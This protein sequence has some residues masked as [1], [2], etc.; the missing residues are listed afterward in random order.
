MVYLKKESKS[1]LT[2]T[3]FLMSLLAA[4]TSVYASHSASTATTSHSFYTFKS[5]SDFSWVGP[6]IGL[7][8]GG[9]SSNAQMSSTVG[10]VTDTSYF[11][12]TADVNSVAQAGSIT[13][14]PSA[15]I[16]GVQF[17]DNLYASHG[18]L[19]GMVLDY[20][21]LHLSQSST[22]NVAYPSGIG[23]Y[24]M[25]TSMDTDWLYTIRGR[26][27]YIPHTSW[28]MMLYGTGGL[29]VTNLRATNSFNDT[30]S[31]AGQGGSSNSNNQTGWTLGLG[32]EFP[33]VQHL[34]INAEYLYLHFGRVTSTGSIQNTSAG[35]GVSANSLTSSV[36]TA[37][38]LHANVFKVGVNYKF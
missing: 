35:F 9:V 22:A 5:S 2:R 25:Q 20:S 18:V 6:Y 37:T 27:G 11:A 8:L 29:A 13:M 21:P 38:N 32:I 14:Q 3:F 28:P 26:L 33:V 10:P 24:T 30:T 34:T 19:F 16:I 31:L 1:Q 4:S 17:G 36:S 15:P 7:T 12:S 23:N